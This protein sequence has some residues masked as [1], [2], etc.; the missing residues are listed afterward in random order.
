MRVAAAEAKIRIEDDANAWAVLAAAVADAG[1]PEMQ[2]FAL[3]AVARLSRP[4]PGSWRSVLEQL[5]E[6]Q[7]GS[8]AYVASAARY[9][10]RNR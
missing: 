2:L 7:A 6:P 8:T 9:L 10:L 1:H 3:N 4:L 5:A